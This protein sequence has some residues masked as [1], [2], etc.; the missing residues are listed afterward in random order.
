MKTNEVS[1]GAKIKEQN[2]L[3]PSV[4]M[5]NYIWVVLAGTFLVTAIYNLNKI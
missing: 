4:E 2:L 3:V 5:H 1:Y